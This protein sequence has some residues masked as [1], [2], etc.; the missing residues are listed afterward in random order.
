MSAEKL[1]RR[2]KN[3]DDPT[4]RTQSNATAA[5]MPPA[6]QPL[7]YAPQGK[8]NMMNNPMNGNSFNEQIGSLSGAN[9]YPYGDGGLPIADGRMG[10]V[11]FIPNSKQLA[12]FG[13]GNAITGRGYQAQVPYGQQQQPN[14]KSQDAMYGIGLAQDS[15]KTLMRQYGEGMPGPYRPGPMGMHPYASPLEGGIANPGQIDPT[16][17]QQMFDTLPTQGMPDAQMAAGMDTGTGGRN[18]SKKA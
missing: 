4:A 3:G 5:G 13:Q 11:G 16:Q 8:G 9:L 7:P 14:N 18:K 1:A 12:E 17:G 2:K 10:G 15:G 6:P